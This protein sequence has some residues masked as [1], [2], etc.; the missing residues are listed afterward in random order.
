MVWLSVADNVCTGT[1]LSV[2]DCS[3]TWSCFNNM[4]LNG[5]EKNRGQIYKTETLKVESSVSFFSLIV[6]CLFFLFPSMYLV[7]RMWMYYWYYVHR[8]C[9]SQIVTMQ[10]IKKKDWGLDKRYWQ[11][12]QYRLKIRW[13][14][15]SKLET[16]VKE[17][18]IANMKLIYHKNANRKYMVFKTE[19]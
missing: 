9:H 11:V 1:H 17:K 16:P 2:S 8:P 7:W 14:R 10:K 18:M 5:R 4:Y 19:F 12:P 3:W 13:T 6:N 15:P